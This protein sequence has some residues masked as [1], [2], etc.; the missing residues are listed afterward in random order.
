MGRGLETD[1]LFTFTI[2][3]LGAERFLQLKEVESLSILSTKRIRRYPF[4]SVQVEV[5]TSHLLQPTH[6]TG[7]R[8]EYPYPCS[9]LIIQVSQQAA[10]LTC[11]YA[12]HY[13]SQASDQTATLTARTG[14]NTFSGYHNPKYKPPTPTPSLTSVLPLASL[15]RIFNL[16]LLSASLPSL[17]PLNSL[18]Y[19]PN[20]T[21]NTSL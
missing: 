21:I 6:A 13:F 4:T 11:R 16:L 18:F 15:P 12:L 1:V 14:S 8:H 2:P 5:I 9:S 10:N 17:P 20:P 3:V 7:V 19:N